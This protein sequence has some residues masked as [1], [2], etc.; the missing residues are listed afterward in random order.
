M[1]FRIKIT[2]EYDGTGYFGFQSQDHQ[3][4]KSIQSKIEFSLYKIFNEKI[5]IYVGGRTDAG[6]HALG[7]VAHFD[8]SIKQLMKFKT[9]HFIEK[10]LISL[11]LITAIN[12]FLKNTNI[13]I[14]DLE[15]FRF[16]DFDYDK[17]IE[18]EEDE[19]V[20]YREILN[21]SSKYENQDF[22]FH[23]RFSAIEKIYQYKIINRKQPLGLFS[24]YFWHISYQID[25]LFDL[26]EISS[27]F[28]GEYDFSA[29]RSKFCQSPKPIRTIKSINVDIKKL[30]NIF[31]E[32]HIVFELRAKS[33]L[34]NQVRLMIGT[35]IDVTRTS[36][37]IF[38]AK[39]KLKEILYSKNRSNTKQKAPACGLYLSKI[40][41]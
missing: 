34:H 13:S 19:E 24:N 37:S 18:C 14:L 7:Q 26:E 23:S 28:V 9:K 11:K 15:I 8:L 31:F 35:I 16:N 12:T 29:F 36:K 38:E 41:Y 30:Q 21:I 6:V 40:L 39:T 27:V 5:T 1:I 4:L 2:I 32:N 3:G 10:N 20:F 22:N 33:F 25:L 17:Y